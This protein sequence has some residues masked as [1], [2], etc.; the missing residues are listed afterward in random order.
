MLN[1]IG[2]TPFLLAAKSD[3]VALMRVLLDL[4]ADASIPPRSGPRR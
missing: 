4:G 3:D 1:H 2:A